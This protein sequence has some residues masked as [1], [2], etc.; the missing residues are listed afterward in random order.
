MKPEPLINS[1]DPF[2]TW[3][4]LKGTF[5]CFLFNNIGFSPLM[6]KNSLEALKITNK[7]LSIFFPP[8]CN[9]IMK[10]F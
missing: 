7:K 9:I 5:V 4:D 2:T 10:D 3:L 6:L 1:F 8:I